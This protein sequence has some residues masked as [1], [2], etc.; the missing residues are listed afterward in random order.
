V[1][2]CA[3]TSIHQK[4]EE[5]AKRFRNAPLPTPTASMNTGRAL[6][7]RSP[8]RLLL[9]GRQGLPTA[10][11]RFE[12]RAGFNLPRGGRSWWVHFNFPPVNIELTF[13]RNQMEDILETA[14]VVAAN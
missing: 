13:L 5:V 6:I 8:P 2:C 4:S 7:V 9:C 10:E 11:G 14:S 12:R 3:G 1:S